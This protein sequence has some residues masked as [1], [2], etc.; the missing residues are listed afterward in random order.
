VIIPSQLASGRIKNGKMVGGEPPHPL[1]WGFYEE[2]L[3]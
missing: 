1:W 2:K 3:R